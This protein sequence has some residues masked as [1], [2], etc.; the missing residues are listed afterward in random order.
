[1]S[2]IQDQSKEIVM[3]KQ[4]LGVDRRVPKPK[5]VISEP[6]F[7]KEPAPQPQNPAYEW[8]IKE[9]LEKTKFKIK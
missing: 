7:P 6:E 1:M 2:Q 9:N 5:P 3:L 4:E 8:V